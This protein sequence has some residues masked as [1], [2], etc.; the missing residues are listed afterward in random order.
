MRFLTLFAILLIALSTASA[1]RLQTDK[2]SKKSFASNQPDCLKGATT[3]KELLAKAGN[4]SEAETAKLTR[5]LQRYG[6]LSASP[7]KT[8]QT[9]STIARRLA[10][11]EEESEMFAEIEEE[12]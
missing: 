11:V 8:N 2:S 12:Q 1:L 3:V 9:D 6:L 10:E 4:C 7:K 5:T